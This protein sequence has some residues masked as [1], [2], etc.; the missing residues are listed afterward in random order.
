MKLRKVYALALALCLGFSL[1]G[2]G[3]YKDANKVTDIH[4]S[5]MEN[6]PN[7]GDMENPS[8]VTVSFKG[9]PFKDLE[10][11]NAQWKIGRA[12]V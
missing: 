1:F 2:C 11:I 5:E 4:S 6:N 12:H 9:I 10:G 3:T 8:S 7:D